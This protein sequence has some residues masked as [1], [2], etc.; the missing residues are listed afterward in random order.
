MDAAYAPVNSSALINV[1]IASTA[2]M[3]TARDERLALFEVA[4]LSVIFV[5]IVFGNCCV[6]VAL[7]PSRLRLRRMYFF[8]LHL[9]LADL[10]TGFFNV[11][12]QLIWDITY[13][14]YGGNVL[15]KTIKLMQVF[16]PYLSSYVLVMTAV[17][18]YQV[19]FHSRLMS[20]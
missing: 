10:I 4:T 2:L 7:F 19:T 11:L 20:H 12:P 8:M 6:L 16:G 15:C 5:T 13:R 17:D 1:S 14:F 9:C 3:S 18:R